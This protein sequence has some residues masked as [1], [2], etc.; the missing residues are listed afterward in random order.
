M[1]EE[2]LREPVKRTEKP[3]Q[4][5]EEQPVPP[6]Q[7]QPWSVPGGGPQITMP[8]TDF[9]PLRPL[10]PADLG[11]AIAQSFMPEMPEFEPLVPDVGEVEE[12]RIPMNRPVAT[13]IGDV[14]PH[15]LAG[16]CI[17]C[18]LYPCDYML[19]RTLRFLLTMVEYGGGASAST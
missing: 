1:S 12:R 11:E 7:E 8:E 16:M 6:E 18:N 2:Q 5:P 9:E 15:G 3:E 13:P 4:V 17:W 19:K 10:E 14:C